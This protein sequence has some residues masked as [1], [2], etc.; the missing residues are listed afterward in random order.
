MAYLIE[1]L[2]KSGS[3]AVWDAGV[4]MGKKWEINCG[5]SGAMGNLWPK[6]TPRD[7]IVD[8]DQIY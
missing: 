7:S 3:V 8:L 4:L 6:W 1:V 5:R 2:E